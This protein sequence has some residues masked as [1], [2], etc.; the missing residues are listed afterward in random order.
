LKHY[1]IYK[2]TFL[3]G[4]LAGCYYIGKHI[5]SK[6]IEND[7][8]FGSGVIPQSYYK[9]YPP[10]IGKT[11]QKEILEICNS[12]EE[13][14]DKEKVW[15]NDLYFTDD[16]CVNQK[17]GGDGGWISR[18]GFKHSEE[19]KSKMRK[20]KTDEFKRKLS[21][22]KKGKKRGPMS[23]EQKEKIRN[24]MKGKNAGV[25]NPMYG[26]S[27]PFKGHKHSIESK[28]MISESKKKTNI[29]KM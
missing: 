27:S 14:A 4:N 23:E 26:K 1:Y 19:T 18:Y 21:E 16:K 9:K 6:N 17:A 22:S 8:Y 25:N 3:C 20:P 13:L 5:T 15:I 2:I 7:N 24:S 29:T 11:I 12:K 28:K 10:I